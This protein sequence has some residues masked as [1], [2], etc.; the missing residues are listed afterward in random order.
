M[1][2]HGH[3]GWMLADYDWSEQTGIATFIYVNESGAKHVTERAQRA[4]LV[5]VVS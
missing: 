3:N 1:I 5:G 2:A 4:W